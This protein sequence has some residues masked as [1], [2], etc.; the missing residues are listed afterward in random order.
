MYVCMY[1][2][3]F[4]LKFKNFECSH[5]LKWSLH[6]IMVCKQIYFAKYIFESVGEI[7]KC[8]H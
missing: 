6:S 8:D 1:V 7:L 2:C 4:V 3:M 5:A